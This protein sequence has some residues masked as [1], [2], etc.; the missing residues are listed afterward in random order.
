MLPGDGGYLALGEEG[1]LWLEGESSP[2]HL[3]VP[4][5]ERFGGPAKRLVGAQ[6]YGDGGFVTL[7]GWCPAPPTWFQR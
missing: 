5:S 4:E 6:P 3:E 2:T 7:D 1:G